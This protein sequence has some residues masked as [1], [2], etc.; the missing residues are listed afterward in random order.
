MDINLK[1]WAS[2]GVLLVMALSVVATL[3]WL[4]AGQ[5]SGTAPAPLPTEVRLP[6]LA[7]AG[8]ISLLVVLAMVAGAFTLFDLSNPRE[9]LGLPEGS[10]RAVIA[11]SLIVL[12]AILVIY[13]YSDMTRPALLQSPSL[14]IEQKDAFLKNIPSQKVIATIPSGEAVN[15]RFTV[16]YNEGSPAAED[17]AKQLLVMIG[18]LVTSVASFYFGT[19]AGT[20]PTDSSIKPKPAL[21]GITP[22]TGTRDTPLSVEISGDSLDLIKEVKITQGSHQILATGVVSSASIVKCQIKVPS[23]TEPD[24]AWTVVVTDGQGQ[25]SALSNALTL[26]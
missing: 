2:G 16:Y 13:L 18:T 9:A 25:T 19:K 24:G 3:Y 20:A 17:F 26:T 23:A 8:L 12:F 5:S 4:I 14:T 1:Q 10:V 7:I 11:L 6:L 21:R 15:Q 22:G